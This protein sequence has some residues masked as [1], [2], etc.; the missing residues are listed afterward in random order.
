MPI[1]FVHGVANRKN[2]EYNEKQAARDAFLKR[3]VAQALG[4]PPNALQV[5]SP[6]WGGHGAKFSWG[7]ASLPEPSKQ[8][9]TFGSE[10]ER[11]AA[12]SAYEHLGVADVRQIDLVSQARELGLPRI[13]DFLWELAALRPK[14]ASHAERV[15]ATFSGAYVYALN[16]PKPAW[17]GK[18][19]LSNSNFVD[20]LQ[21]EVSTFM[22]S[23]PAAQRQEWETF[24]ISEFWDDV[25]EGFDRLVSAPGAALSSA[26][27]TVARAAL[28]DKA[29]VFIGDAFSY[30]KNRGNSG[31]PGPIV[32]TVVADFLQAKQIREQKNEPF[33]V[34]AH[35]FGGIISFDIF[36]H[37]MPTLPVDLFLSVGS[38]VALFEE[39][40]LYHSS[41]ADVPSAST[42]KVAKPRNVKRWLNIFDLNDVLSYCCAGVFDGVQDFMYPTGSSVLSAHSAYFV[43]PSFYFR[44]SERI[45]Q[46]R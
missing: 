17:L 31:D 3:Y 29:S 36:S 20:Q 22:D 26:V 15:A 32:Q 41:R 21:V 44:L 34:I 5:F 9:E 46:P 6:Y 19:G 37:Y 18:A 10:D 42:P 30:L 1:V 38:Q 35:S 13:V 43:R 33:V 8:Y 45:K 7:Q 16:F 40:K 12:Y 11:A 14:D 4:T 2:A 23:K 27:V 39:M 25:R 28:N 24:G